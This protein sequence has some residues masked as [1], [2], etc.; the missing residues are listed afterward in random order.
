VLRAD[1]VEVVGGL[2]DVFQD[3][4]VVVVA[5]YQGL[6]VPE[7]TDLRRQMR[8]AGGTFRVTKNRLARIAL[9]GT[10]YDPMADLFQGPTAIAFSDDPVAAPRV[11]VGYAKKNEKVAIIGGALAGRL[12]EPRQV[13]ELADL[14]PIEDLRAR[15]IGVINAPA[16]KLARL[17]QTPGGQLARVLQARSEQAASEQGEAA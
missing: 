4:G 1:K 13:R 10:A 12:L 16:S 14:P 9:E 8:A 5:H 7:I 2:R 15:L 6:T 11:L 17:L 3:A